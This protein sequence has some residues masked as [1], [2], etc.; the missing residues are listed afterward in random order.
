MVVRTRS[1]PSLLLSRG[2]LALLG[3]FAVGND[4]SAREACP[5]GM[6]SSGSTCCAVEAE[7]VESKNACMPY[8]PER[9]CAEG[10]LDACIAAARE[11]ESKST[12]AAGYAAELY[13]F[14]C[15]SG[16][17]AGC[18]G[19]GLLYRDGQGLDADLVRARAL[20][21]RA[22]SEGDALSCVDASELTLAVS[23]DAIQA[24]D[25]LV[26]ACNRG[27]GSACVRVLRAEQAA[28]TVSSERER[29]LL[30]QACSGGDAEGCSL[31]GDAFLDGL[32]A[33]QNSTHAATHYRA[34][35]EAGLS[36]AC[37]RLAVLTEEGDGVIRDAGAAVALYARACGAG[38]EPACARHSSITRAQQT[39][40]RGAREP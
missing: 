34:A 7:Y 22:C 28:A 2:L 16:A 9:H 24:A 12:V 10:R 40:L 33:P 17:A 30:E 32:I 35:C 6:A 13:R 26:Q 25:L 3:A 36:Y 27:A 18:R 20:L 39:P 15:E 14:A 19:L 23:S 21:E 5:L 11:L 31:L 4:A 1:N 8:R 38:L 29:R 37:L